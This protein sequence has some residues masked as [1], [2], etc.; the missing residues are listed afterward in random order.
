MKRHRKH[1]NKFWI[2]QKLGFHSSPLRKN[3]QEAVEMNDLMNIPDVR[4][5]KSVSCRDRPTGKID[6]E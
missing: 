4:A 3:P 6:N 2:G 1:T 5:R